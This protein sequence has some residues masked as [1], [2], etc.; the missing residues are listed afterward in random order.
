MQR[1]IV[2][3]VPTT[4]FSNENCLLE[5]FVQLYVKHQIVIIFSIFLIA[6]FER[7]VFLGCKCSV[8]LKYYCGGANTATGFLIEI[9]CR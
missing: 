5:A 6:W 2:Q 1:G 8:S 4:F 9:F 7:L 3:C